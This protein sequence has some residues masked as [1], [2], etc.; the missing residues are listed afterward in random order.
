VFLECKISHS[1]FSWPGKGTLVIF[2]LQKHTLILPFFR[3]YQV[4]QYPMKKLLPAKNSFKY[5]YVPLKIRFMW[6]HNIYYLLRNLFGWSFECNWTEF[7]SVDS[8]RIGVSARWLWTLRTVLWCEGIDG[9]KWAR[10][11]WTVRYTIRKI[12]R[13][14]FYTL[15]SALEFWKI[16]RGWEKIKIKFEF[17]HYLLT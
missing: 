9:V 8:C 16:F 12:R 2:S 1:C 3:K 13:D 7:G 14:I 15:F 11:E 5:T 4:R 10:N 17:S 6:S